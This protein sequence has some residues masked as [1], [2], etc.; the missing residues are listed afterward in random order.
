[1][2]TV[3]VIVTGGKV[4]LPCYLDLI[5][6]DGLA[7]AVLRYK[8]KRYVSAKQIRMY[9]AVT[10]IV[11]KL[12]ENGFRIKVCHSCGFF[13]QKIDG[14][15]NVVKGECMKCKMKSSACEPTE[16]LIWSTCADYAP[17]ELGKVID[18]KNY[19]N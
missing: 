7:H 10:D 5:S 15:T 16:T 6:E 3:D 9:D 17:R 4:D 11:E 8:K 14:S 19:R 2:L 1:M 13:T 12:D 18:I